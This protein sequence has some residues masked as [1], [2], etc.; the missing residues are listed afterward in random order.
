MRNGVRIWGGD[1]INH[2]QEN[3][4][5]YLVTDPVPDEIDINTSPSLTPSEARWIVSA[6][7]G[8][9][10]PFAREPIVEL[11][12]LPDMKRVRRED[13]APV[14][15]GDI[16]NAV[17][18][19]E[20]PVGYHLAY[21]VEAA[22][23]ND[24]DGIMLAG[25]LVEAHGG[26]ILRKWSALETTAGSGNSQYS[27]T[28][29]LSTATGTQGFE[30]RD[31]DRGSHTTLDLNH[32]WDMAA[33]G[34]L[35]V[36]ADNTWG[37]G[38]QYVV[39]G[40][41][42]STN[43]QT[44][45]VD[46]HY[47]AQV[48][49][50]FYRQVLG[51]NGIDGNGTPTRV[52][53]HFA[54][55]YDNAFWW[56]AC[57]C[58][59]FGDGNQFKTLTPL[60]VVGHEFSHGVTSATADLIYMGESG[61]LN[62]ATSDIL[63][64][65]IEFYGRGAGG[66]GSLI[67]DSGGDWTIGEQMKTP[68]FDRPLRYMYKPSLDGG[69]P[70]AWSSSLSSLDVHYGSGPM[71]RCFY[72]LSQ[73]ASPD[74]AST[75][76][77]S[78]LP[79][80]MTGIGNDRAA[81]IW[82]R[83]LT[84]YLTSSSNYLHARMASLRSAIDL[85]GA[86]APE[87]QAVR[88]AFAAINVGYASGAGDDLE[89]PTVSASVTGASG[90]IQFTAKVHD[91]VGVARLVFYVDQYRIGTQDAGGKPDDS[92]TLSFDSRTIPKGDHILTVSAAD[93]VGNVTHSAPV[94]FQVSNTFYELILQGDFEFGSI[95]DGG[96]DQGNMAW[97]D[98]QGV[99]TDTGW[100]Y[101]GWWCAD[102]CGQGAANT[103]SIH[104]TVTIP[105]GAQKAILSFWLEVFSDESDGMVHD[106]FQVQVRSTAGDLIETL[107][108]YSNLDRSKLLIPVPAKK[109]YSQRFIDLSAYRGKTIQ[110]WFEGHED[111]AHP[112]SVFNPGSTPALA[113]KM[114]PVIPIPGRDPSSMTQWSQ[115]Q[116]ASVYPVGVGLTE[117]LLDNVSLRIGETAD[118]QP[119]VPS[120]RGI[121]G[122]YGNL[123]L[124]GDVSD[125]FAIARVDYL[126]DG[127]VV[128][129]TTAGPHRLS[130]DSRSIPDATHTFVVN[131]Y[132]LAGNKGSSPALSFQTD[133]SFSQCLKNPGFESGFTGWTFTN[134]NLAWLAP[135]YDTEV[136][137]LALNK[138]VFG[139]PQP[140]ALTQ[141]VSIPTNVQSARL[142][143]SYAMQSYSNPPDDS[144]KVQIWNPNGFM[145]GTLATFSP[146][147]TDP[148]Y[149][150]AD[151]D[152]MAYRGQDVIVAFVMNTLSQ[153]E[154]GGIKGLMVNLDR[155][156][157]VVQAAL[158]PTILTQ[159][160]S[161][162]VR[163]SGQATFSVIAGGTSPLTY[164][165]RKDTVA[166]PGANGASLTL[167]SATTGDAGSYDL[168]V[169]NFLGN[170]VSEPATLTVTRNPL[171]LNSDGDVNVL[172]LA[173]LIKNHAPGTP[174]AGSI[175]DLN[176]DGFVDDADLALLLAGL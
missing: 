167:A 163:I 57:F 8:S 118:T 25:Y 30:L 115:G 26:A 172:D 37:D 107:A 159:P 78:Y 12:I 150:N 176:G 55:A 156:D 90:I 14:R 48:T 56:D 141:A 64:T 71:N 138:G 144:L 1:G 113:G 95:Y 131:A 61:S 153:P 123:D 149:G 136:I 94:P 125:N 19:V 43:G 21:H 49:W 59:T 20:K 87:V 83:A 161:Q 168:V 148:Y 151:I 134:W 35:Y 100:P 175:A 34:N 132:D 63:G 46:A 70:D 3:G 97:V 85:Y 101:L 33:G 2:T 10:G 116:G 135:T 5:E 66:Q 146:P 106:T 129:S 162:S 36:D 104:Q 77:S 76:Y 84:T 108:T 89:P 28:V 23:S 114:P 171:D 74:A 65:M 15:T 160:A 170:A 102:F 145:M 18:V 68:L 29:A 88:N 11:V 147:G 158:P 112:T 130:F 13:G 42:T 67:P 169:T 154:S 75:A 38:Q 173:W 121:K 137:T 110:L 127:K 109:D 155:V 143:F 166:I 22:V 39:G 133:N 31:L 60:D 120:A 128:G 140:T 51:R 99:I 9:R 27:G 79:T 41:T 92:Q 17:E 103:Q 93:L 164:Q 47:G 152:L 53:V 126:I 45:A 124:V 165:W 52:R 73:G 32:S 157:L 50:D 80:G 82:Y 86:V 54:D 4:K 62:E 119:P 96:V 7:L 122:T 117:F 81:R 142:K 16:L 40:S 44:A 139:P 105:A 98:P 69:S 91:N 58:M 24:Q 174:I 6:D 72:F 111:A